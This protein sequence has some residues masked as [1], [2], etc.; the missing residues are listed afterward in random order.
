MSEMDDLLAA[1]RRHVRIPWET[2]LAGAQKVWFVIYDPVQERRLR[3]RLDEFRQATTQSG[4]GWHMVDV[5]DSFGRWMAGQEY[6][7]A[8]FEEPDYLADKMPEFATVVAEEV[9]TAL[10]AREHD[11]QTVVAILGVGALFGLT[12]VASLMETVAPKIRG[13][14]LVFFPGSY[15][16]STYR[17][18]DAR[19]GWNY[20]AVPIT[21]SQG[22]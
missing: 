4:H 1:F 2:G 6:R 15:D 17:L 13:R 5:T 19:D 8:Y 7:E 20:L 22:A 11:D 12:R 18:L 9:T 10:T 14:L 16:G 21:A 3:L